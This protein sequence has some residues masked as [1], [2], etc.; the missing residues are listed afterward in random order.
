MFGIEGHSNELLAPL[1][2]GVTL[3]ISWVFVQVVFANYYA[4][5]FYRQNV[6]SSK[7]WIRIS[8]KSSTKLLGFHPFCVWHRYQNSSAARARHKQENA[9]GASRT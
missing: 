1:L 5:E 7:P 8:K 3:P 9:H 4:H 6:N 2:A